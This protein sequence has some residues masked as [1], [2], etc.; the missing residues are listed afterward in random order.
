MKVKLTI[1]SGCSF[2]IP[3]A[4]LTKIIELL[5]D[6]L[7]E[8]IFL[9]KL[10]CH[11]SSYVRSAVAAMPELESGTLER[12]ARD[13][14]IDVLRKVANNKRALRMFKNQLILEMIG[15]DVSVANVIAENLPY[16]LDDSREEIIQNLLSHPDPCVVETTNIYKSVQVEWLAEDYDTW[17]MIQNAGLR[18]R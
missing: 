7:P 11:Q 12:L 5:A 18:E 8:G 4:E 2:E 9:S 17:M 15:R 16:I 14:S 6:K 10:A 3:Y 1:D 13:V